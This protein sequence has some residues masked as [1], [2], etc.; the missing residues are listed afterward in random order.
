M[1]L[2]ASENW[3]QSKIL[4]SVIIKA[5][6][7]CASITGKQLLIVR[8]A[9]CERKVGPLDENQNALIDSAFLYFYNDI[10]A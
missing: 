5:Q 10:Q 4:Q 8:I 3:C 2:S 6:R 1:L 7:F 9:F